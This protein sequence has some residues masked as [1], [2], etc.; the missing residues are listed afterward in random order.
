MRRG[1]GRLPEEKGVERSDV[2]GRGGE[3]GGEG[4]VEELA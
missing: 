2:G 3:G 1:R 4:K